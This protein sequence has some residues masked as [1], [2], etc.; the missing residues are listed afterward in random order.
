MSSGPSESSLAA[1]ILTLNKAYILQSRVSYSFLDVATV[2]SFGNDKK[3]YTKQSQR[4]GKIAQFKKKRNLSIVF[5]R[6]G[7]VWILA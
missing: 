7:L 4:M 3:S 1:E 2:R 5:F 6:D